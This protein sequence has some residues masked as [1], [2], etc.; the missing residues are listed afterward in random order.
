MLSLGGHQMET[1]LY[2]LVLS[3][4]ATRIE[5]YLIFT[6]CDPPSSNAGARPRTFFPENA[7]RICA[8]SET[9]KTTILNAMTDGN[10][11]GKML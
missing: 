11:I 7:Y 3:I 4:A 8:T 6:L 2:A 10:E 1:L 5:A 9:T